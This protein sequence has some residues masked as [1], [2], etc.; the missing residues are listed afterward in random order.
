M[1]LL[2]INGKDFK[3]RD[4]N[5]KLSLLIKEILPLSEDDSINIASEIEYYG[6][7]YNKNYVVARLNN[8]QKFF[9]SI[10]YVIIHKV[11]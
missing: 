6:Q 2:I 11:I 3:A 10:L 5:P 8:N 7:L 4:L 9:Y 1:Y